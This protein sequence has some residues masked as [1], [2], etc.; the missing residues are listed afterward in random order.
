MARRVRDRASRVGDAVGAVG[1]VKS[2]D[3]HLQTIVETVAPL[4]ELDL[5]LLDA[6]GCVLAE[7]V[8]AG[9]SLPSFDNSSMDGYAV[10]VADVAHASEA[11]PV[12]LPVVADIAAGATGGYS[13]QSGL[14]VRIMTGAPVPPGADA[15][16][17]VEWTDG[18]VASVEIRRAPAPGQYIRRV[19]EDVMAGTTVLAAGTYLQAPQLGLL[20]AVGR[21]RVRARPKP[22]VVIVSTGSE[23]VEV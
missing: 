1:P 2:V 8:V 3:A 19:G 9:T 15:V 14:C 11:M 18:G 7:D 17:P 23:L 13:V 21:A 5:T 4:P 6:H 10:R 16:V 22:R 20:A 12:R